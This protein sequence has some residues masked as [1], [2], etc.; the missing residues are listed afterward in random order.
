MNAAELSEQAQA[1]LSR[2]MPHLHRRPDLPGLARATLQVQRMARRE[3]AR[4]QALVEAVAAD[5]GLSARLLRLSNSAVHASAGA[6]RNASLERAVRLLGFAT[7]QQLASGLPLLDRLRDGRAA[8]LVREDFLR[9]LLAAQL[10]RELSR[11]WRD[12][13]AAQLAA[14]FQNLGRMLVAT[15]LPDDA[16]AI[17]AAV[18]RSRW[19]LAD[20]EQLAARRRLG[21]RYADLGLHVARHWG[22]PEAVR[23]TLPAVDEWPAQRPHDART[24]Q[25]LLGR[26]ANEL[27]DLMLYVEPARW[28][29]ACDAL[30]ALVQRASGHDAE[31][32]RQALARV[33]PRLEALA[34]L[35]ELPRSERRDW[36]LADVVMG[37]VDEVAEPHPDPGPL[38]E[39]G[40]GPAPMATPVAAA[41]APASRAPD[42]HVL[43][44]LHAALSARRAVLW[45]AGADGASMVLQQVLG[46][47]LPDDVR[48]DWRIDPLLGNDLFSRLCRHGHD[49]L[50]RDARDPR[51]ARHLP[52]AYRR[53]VGAGSFLV[54]PLRRRGVFG[55]LLYLD[56]PDERPF[57][58][59]GDAMQLVR[60][61]RDQATRDWV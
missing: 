33:H 55:G 17:R 20:R 60:T 2:L 56:R 52:P 1:T 41:P 46:A 16:C 27:A 34:E 5:P 36:Q 10:A 53:G 35:V 30:H 43:H 8:R 28:P 14:T 38:S 39:P 18:P 45:R 61:V 48:H 25:R 13:D 58:L 49:A 21:W 15:H 32:L 6:G 40:P 4:V 11:D 19:P 7:V 9:A 37:A 26:L 42:E 50:I 23:G 22:W 24:R 59:D 31:S 3:N 54:L 29:Q 57:T 51:I 12:T 44:Q 47:P